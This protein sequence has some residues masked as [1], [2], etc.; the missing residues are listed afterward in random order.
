MKKIEIRCSLFIR[1][2]ILMALAAASYAWSQGEETSAAV[3]EEQNSERATCQCGEEQQRWEQSLQSDKPVFL[4]SGPYLA[5]VNV[6]SPN[7]APDASSKDAV[8]KQLKEEDRKKV[9]KILKRSKLV[10][11][12]VMT[13]TEAQP[14]FQLQL[15]EG[16][17]INGRVLDNQVFLSWVVCSRED[18]TALTTLLKPYL[19]EMSVWNEKN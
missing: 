12:R 8:R 5:K 17:L 2:A 1:P 16:Y 19:K 18:R 11:L 9:L 10:E 6:M 7:N 13:R 3:S 4:L 14:D 15:G